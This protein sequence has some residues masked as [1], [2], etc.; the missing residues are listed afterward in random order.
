[1]TNRTP[2]P[3][4]CL[5]RGCQKGPQQRGLCYTCYKNARKAI[6][7]GHAS[8]NELIRLGMIR[9]AQHGGRRN[10][11]LEDLS[12]RRRRATEGEAGK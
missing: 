11:F 5:T 4:K 6:N 10:P 9:E 7:D 2:L 3:E 12:E 1:M 8:E